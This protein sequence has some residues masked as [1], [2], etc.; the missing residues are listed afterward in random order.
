MDPPVGVDRLGRYE[1]LR[2]IA[3]GGMGT[4]W[5]ARLVGPD[6]IHRYLALKILGGGDPE[7]VTMFLHE[8]RVIASLHHANVVH[9]YDVGVADDGRHYL[10]ME[11]LHG[12]SLRAVLDR[13]YQVRAEL[14]LGFGLA[15]AIAA[16]AGLHHAHERR[17]PGGPLGIVHR[18]ISPSNIMVGH[19]GVVKLIDFGIAD[20]TIRV[21]E[22]RRGLIKGKTAYMSPEQL[23]EEPLDRRSDVFALGIVAYEATTQARAFR[24]A[25]ELET[26]R[27]I[28]HGKVMPPAR[29]RPGYPADLA[30]TVLAAL[31]V[32]PAD[33]FASAA[34]L[35]DALAR[36]AARLGLAVGPAAITEVMQ[37][38][39]PDAHEPWV[40]RRRG[41]ARGSGGHH[42]PP[43]AR[44]VDD[45]VTARFVS[46][47]A[48]ALEPSVVVSMDELQAVVIDD[49]DVVSIDDM[50][51]PS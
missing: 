7:L 48:D 11:Y 39:F 18:D 36:T 2:P 15:V 10:A 1:L 41:F 24:A 51:D 46:L 6:G 21:D 5:L 25:S 42:T 43:E 50:V 28:V 17:G 45:E 16:A 38:L 20:S 40:P 22:T 31:A 34:E 9:V 35:G 14:P 29:A 27:R 37:R 49:I 12:V 47:E 4:V 3:T 23:L 44:A 8:A 19:D 30:T 32:D 33:R 26:A 13:A